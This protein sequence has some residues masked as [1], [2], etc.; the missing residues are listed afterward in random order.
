MIR[1][2]VPSKELTEFGYSGC[3]LSLFLG[4]LF[5]GQW[6]QSPKGGPRRV[7]DFFKKFF[8]SKRVHAIKFLLLQ[9]CCERE[10]VVVAKE[11]MLLLL[12]KE[13]LLLQ[14][15]LKRHFDQPLH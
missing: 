5:P 12:R 9:R 3:L 11:K 10:V 15:R 2:F 6:F 14:K 1:T 7:E 4:Q 13:V 8:V